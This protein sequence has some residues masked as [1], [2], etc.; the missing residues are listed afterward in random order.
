MAASTALAVSPQPATRATDPA[1]DGDAP[2][3]ATVRAAI[4]AELRARDVF[5]TLPPVEELMEAL[6]ARLLADSADADALLPHRTLVMQT[7]V[8]CQ[9]R[10]QAEERSEA[11]LRELA[12]LDPAVAA[13]AAEAAALA[14]AVDPVR[15]HGSWDPV[16]REQAG[17]LRKHLDAAPRPPRPRSRG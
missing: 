10:L 13:A 12:N 9:R 2:G 15:H 1:F 14:A 5:S 6:H 8:A 7:A 3:A 4:E 16:L 11:A 17:A